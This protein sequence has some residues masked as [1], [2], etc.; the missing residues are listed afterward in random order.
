MY[1]RADG[2]FVPVGIT[3]TSGQVSEGVFTPMSVSQMEYDE[4][5]YDSDFSTYPAY[6]TGEGDEGWVIFIH[7]FRGDHRRQTFAL[8]RA[9]ELDEIGWKS[10]IIAYRNGDGMKQ[11]P[12]GMYLYGATEWVDLDGAIDY[13]INNGAKKVVLFGISGGGGPEASWIMNTNEPEKVDGFIYEAPTFNFI[14]SVKV[15]GQARFPWLPVS[16]FDY[17]IWLSEIRFGIDFDSMDFR[18]DLIDSQIPALLFHGD[19][20]EWVPVSMSDFIA[21]NSCLLYTSDAADE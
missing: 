14:E 18:Y 10:M 11:D 9:K 1:E 6:I 12:S 21:S 15:N 5:F 4:V 19:D 13:A 20:D 3:E 8:L 17:F 7:G 2:N 16:L